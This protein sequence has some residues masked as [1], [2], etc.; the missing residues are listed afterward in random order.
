MLNE[1]RD[2]STGRLPQRT[3]QLE[4]TQRKGMLKRGAG[5][6]APGCH[7]PPLPLPPGPP[8]RCP[9]RR[10]TQRC[11]WC[12]WRW[13]LGR[14]PSLVGAVPRWRSR[15]SCCWSRSSTCMTEELPVRRAT[16]AAVLPSQSAVSRLSLPPASTRERSREAE[17]LRAA[18]GAGRGGRSAVE[19][20]GLQ[21]SLLCTDV[22]Q[23]EIQWPLACMLAKTMRTDVHHGLSIA[24][25][26]AY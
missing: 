17:P 21:V 5:S 14:G 13:S 15:A 7:W 16:S 22:Q 11:G 3:A 23:C 24:I 2:K 18:A 25:S 19:R 9:R 6:A 4:K 20:Q 26:T 10:P 8:L 1:G 12:C